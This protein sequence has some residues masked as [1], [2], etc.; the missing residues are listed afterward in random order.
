MRCALFDDPPTALTVV[1]KEIS[2]HGWRPERSGKLRD[3]WDAR[4]AAL[5]AVEAAI[6]SMERKP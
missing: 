1:Q 2:K 3:T 6:Y 4:H 5:I